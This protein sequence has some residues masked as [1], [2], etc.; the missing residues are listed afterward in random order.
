MMFDN[1][2]FGLARFFVLDGDLLAEHD[3]FL[4]PL[5]QPLLIHVAGALYDL[6]R[7]V[8]L[9]FGHVN[10]TTPRHLLE[11]GIVDVSPVDGQ[12]IPTAEFAG[13][14]HEMVVG[15]C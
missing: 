12:D 3:E 15:G 1:L 14:Q 9:H 7:E 11:L 4:L 13:A 2:L 6:I 8:L 10:D 5:H